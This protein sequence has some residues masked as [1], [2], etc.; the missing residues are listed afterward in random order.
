MAEKAPVD[1]WELENAVAAEG[2]SLVCG[3]DEAGRGA[4][5]DLS[6]YLYLPILF[7]FLS[8]LSRRFRSTY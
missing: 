6:V 4:S 2:Y 3:V 5:G 1:L 7:F 8:L